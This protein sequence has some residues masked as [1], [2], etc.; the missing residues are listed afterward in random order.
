MTSVVADN[1]ALG[2]GGQEI[3]L[4]GDTDKEEFARNLQTLL[5]GDEVHNQVWGIAIDVN[6]T[7]GEQGAAAGPFI[8]FT[9]LA[10]DTSTAG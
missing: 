4:G 8:G 7:S 5:R 6:L 1:E 3:R 9:I 10:P 2:G